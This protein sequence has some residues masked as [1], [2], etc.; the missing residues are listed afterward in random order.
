MKFSFLVFLTSYHFCLTLLFNGLKSNDL[1][2][3]NFQ[4]MY[5]KE[6]KGTNLLP[7]F[8][9]LQNWRKFIFSKNISSIST[10]GNYKTLNKFFLLN[11]TTCLGLKYPYLLMIKIKFFCVSLQTYFLLFFPWSTN[12]S[13]AGENGIVHSLHQPWIYNGVSC[14]TSGVDYV[15]LSNFEVLKTT[16][17]PDISPRN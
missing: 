5:F 6:C 11:I 12:H 14:G 1:N 7:E 9:T 10:Y 15:V 16:S 3:N 4:E 2:N 13:G 17:F 8:K